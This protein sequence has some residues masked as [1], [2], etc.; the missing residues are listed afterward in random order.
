MGDHSP[1][2]TSVLVLDA[3]FILTWKFWLWVSNWH[4]LATFRR[5]NPV[6]IFSYAS[7]LFVYDI[8]VEF[9]EDLQV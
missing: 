7:L 5:T 8:I 4:V 1:K 6:E 2:P 3:L 9:A